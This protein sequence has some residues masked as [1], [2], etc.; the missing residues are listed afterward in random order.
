M[1]E[2]GMITDCKTLI[3]HSSTAEKKKIWRAVLISDKA[4]FRRRKVIRD[5][6]RYYTIIVSLFKEDISQQK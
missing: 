5:K 4:D 6:E 1:Y 3:S 2:S